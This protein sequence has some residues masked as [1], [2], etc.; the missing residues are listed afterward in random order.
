MRK[1]STIALVIVCCL[2]VWLS[3][4]Y[5]IINSQVA[6]YGIIRIVEFNKVIRWLE[7]GGAIA[8]FGLGIYV[9]SDI[10]RGRLP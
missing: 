6:Q 10:L 4:Y 2:F 3:F 9:L 1:K 7:L 5:I 8:M